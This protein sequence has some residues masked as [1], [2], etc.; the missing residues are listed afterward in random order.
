MLRFTLS[1]LTPPP[2]NLQTMTKL[3]KNTLRICA[4]PLQSI[5]VAL[6]GFI[7]CASAI[8]ANVETHIPGTTYVAK[9]SEV[10]AGDTAWV[11]T[12]AVLVLM[13][14]LPGLAFFY[15][16]LVRKKNILSTM[17][18]IFAV[19]CS[20][21]VL[22]FVVTYSLAFSQNSP[23][24]GGLSKMINGKFL[25]LVPGVSMDA[26][27]PGI[28]ETVFALFECGFAVIAAALIVGAF[29]E[30]VRFGVAVLFCTLWS[31]FVYAP[32][33]HWVWSPEGWAYTMGVRDYAGGLAVHVNAGAAALA[34]ALVVGARRGFGNEAMVPAN[35]AYMLIGAGMLVVGW[36]G[37]NGGSAMGANAAAG[38]A[39][40]NTFVSATCSAIVFILLEWLLRGKATL[41]G[42]SAGAV[43]GLV[44]I[45]P[46]AGY[47]T[48]DSALVFGATGGLVSFAGLNWVKSRTGIDDTLDVF[49]IHGLVGIAG[50]I[51]T[52]LFSL[53]ELSGTPGSFTAELAAAGA[54]FAYSFT[55]SWLLMKLLD[56]VVGARVSEAGEMD[57]LDL[58]QHGEG[59]D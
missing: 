35:L 19:A 34:C 14:T 43:A 47:I 40:V 41:V 28:P 48:A 16:G 21:S 20:V 10:S 31:L 42:I 38:F 11:L 52:P 26:F 44:A 29:A 12:S 9:A 57:G 27:A 32:V 58:S 1:L 55:V 22:W 23:W 36:F 33:A 4:K 24:L 15:G 8:A 17:S 39:S 30:R 6:A 37:F 25:S 53:P 45:T 7:A 46:A 51:L 50:S 2:E 18:Q 54:V 3:S 56:L 5:G 59:H 49:A 13:M